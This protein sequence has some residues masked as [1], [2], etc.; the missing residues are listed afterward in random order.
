MLQVCLENHAELKELQLGGPSSS[1]DRRVRVD[2]KHRELEDAAYELLDA[3][4]RVLQWRYVALRIH[5]LM[6][7]FCCRVS[8]ACSSRD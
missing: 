7:S 4:K 5:T 1:Q 3:L 6:A 2:L 8:F